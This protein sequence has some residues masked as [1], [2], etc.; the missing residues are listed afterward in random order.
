[1]GS[2]CGAAEASGDTPTRIELR[3]RERRFPVRRIGSAFAAGGP[4]PVRPH[5]VRNPLH[6][7]PDSAH[8]VNLDRR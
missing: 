2:P 6:A 5:N 7:A 8:L 3:G 4:P 1:M